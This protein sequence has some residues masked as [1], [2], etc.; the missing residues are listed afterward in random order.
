MH[1]WR[2]HLFDFFYVF[3]FKYEHLL[4]NIITKTGNETQ[5]TTYSYKG[6]FSDTK[7]V[8]SNIYL[9]C[10]NSLACQC[11]HAVMLSCGVQLV[12]WT[13][14]VWAYAL[15]WAMAITTLAT[16]DKLACC[17]VQMVIHVSQPGIMLDVF[18]D[19]YLS[20][21]IAS[22]MCQYLV[23]VINNNAIDIFSSLLVTREFNKITL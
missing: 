23:L 9:H 3:T 17:C 14:P 10:H 12:C 4:S 20:I 21:L 6:K 5:Y 15:L 22:L 16:N 11:H 18:R 13:A 19:I 8:H 1:I 2:L 7:Y